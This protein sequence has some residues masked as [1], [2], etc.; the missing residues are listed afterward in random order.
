MQ[1]STH[2]VSIYKDSSPSVSQCMIQT[3]STQQMSTPATSQHRKKIQFT[4]KEASPIEVRL[5][6]GGR[7]GTGGEVMEG[8]W[9]YTERGGVAE[10]EG[11]GM[12]GGGGVGTCIDRSS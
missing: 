4:F 5:F 9:G 2:N 6:G 10:E 7:S 3:I 12:V 11:G 8:G 1:V